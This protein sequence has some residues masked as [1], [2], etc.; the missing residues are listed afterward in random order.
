MSIHYNSYKLI[1]IEL[2]APNSQTQTSIFDFCPQ[3]VCSNMNITED[4]QLPSAR[5]FYSNPDNQTTSV[6]DIC[7]GY[8]EHGNG[9]SCC[10]SKEIVKRN[11][12]IWAQK[13]KQIC[14]QRRSTKKEQEYKDRY[15]REREQ[16]ERWAQKW[17]FC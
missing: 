6:I 15:D 14:K 7:F 17:G 8:V 16:F 13:W 9:C 3:H 4:D 5:E 10:S 1:D 12:E 2:G 11:E